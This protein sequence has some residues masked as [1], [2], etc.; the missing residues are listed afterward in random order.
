MSKDEFMREW[1]EAIEKGKASNRLAE[2]RI[3]KAFMVAFLALFFLC[4]VFFWGVSYDFK[5]PR[6]GSEATCPEGYVCERGEFYPS[7]F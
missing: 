1:G 5:L 2:E 6:F 4:G 3:S 7:G